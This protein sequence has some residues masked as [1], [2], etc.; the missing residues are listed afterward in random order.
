MEKIHQVRKTC[1]ENAVMKT[2]VHKHGGAWLGALK[3][4]SCRLGNTMVGQKTEM[5]YTGDHS[6]GKENA[7]LWV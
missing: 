5:G 3:N 4:S 7:G 2:P 6:A 1:A